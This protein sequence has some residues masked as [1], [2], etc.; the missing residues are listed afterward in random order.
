MSYPASQGTRYSCSISTLMVPTVNLVPRMSMVILGKPWALSLLST[1]S[2]TAWRWAA[3][4]FQHRIL[5]V[6]LDPK[7]SRRFVG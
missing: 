4:C 5:S 3:F 1:C 2:L 6:L 7:C